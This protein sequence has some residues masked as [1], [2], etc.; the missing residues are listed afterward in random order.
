M[1]IVQGVCMLEAS[2]LYTFQNDQ[3]LK[4]RTKL[5]NAPMQILSDM[6]F[7]EIREPT[8]KIEKH[9]GPRNFRAQHIIHE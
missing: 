4:S 5:A 3:S 6:P 8:R 2:D 1:E 9:H 7:R